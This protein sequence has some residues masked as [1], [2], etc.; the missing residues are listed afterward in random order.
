MEISPSS[1][2]FYYL[3]G[4]WDENADPRME[5]FPIMRGGPWLLLS[6]LSAYLYFVNSW[7][8]KFMENRKPYVLRGT[9]FI[10]NVLMVIANCWIFYQAF[11]LLNYGLDTW[12]CLPKDP[13]V[14]NPNNTSPKSW[15]LIQLAYYY[16][17]TKIIEL[18]DTVFFVL[19]KKNNQISRLHVIHHS[20]VPL[21]CWIAGKVLSNSYASFSVAF[22]PLIN[23]FVHIIMYSY[24]ALAAL[25]PGIQKYLWW[26][27]YLTQLQLSQ[28][29]LIFIHS[30]HFMFIPNCEYPRIFTYLGIFNAVM[31]FVLFFHFYVRAYFTGSEKGTKKC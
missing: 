18:M 29:V 27:K 15:R 19:R 5:Q 7:G 16:F 31:F 22:F 14:G 21:V 1:T 23:M 30:S 24:Y 10:Y 3:D 6:I 11:N 28:F 17:L 25:G 4:Y 8:P 9:I 2:F 26:K 20:S 13:G 12:G